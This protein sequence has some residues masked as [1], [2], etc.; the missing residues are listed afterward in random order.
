[1][2]RMD[3]VPIYIYIHFVH[4]NPSWMCF[5]LILFNTLNITIIFSY[6][7]YLFTCH[8]NCLQ[9]WPLVTS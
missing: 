8:Q 7:P 6:S 1:M 2:G 3:Y 9:L 5:E 4:Q